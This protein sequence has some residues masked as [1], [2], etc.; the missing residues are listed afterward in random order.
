VLQERHKKVLTAGKHVCCIRLHNARRPGPAHASQSSTHAAAKP[1][2]RCYYKGCLHHGKRSSRNHPHHTTASAAHALHPRWLP[3]CMPHAHHTVGVAA[4]HDTCS[5]LLPAFVTPLHG[6]QVSHPPISYCTTLCQLHRAQLHPKRAAQC[7]PGT[8]GSPTQRLPTAMCVR[9]PVRHPLFCI[10]ARHQQLS[11]PNPSS[12]LLA[13]LLAA[14][15]A[16]ATPA[17][18]QQSTKQRCQPMPHKHIKQANLGSTTET[19]AMLSHGQPASV[20]AIVTQHRSAANLQTQAS[21]K[22]PW[23]RQRQAL[24][25]GETM[26]NISVTS[27]QILQHPSA[28]PSA[29]IRCGT[30]K[31]IVTSPAHTQQLNSGHCRT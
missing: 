12:Q 29:C 17:T 3:H 10:C 13:R 26:V 22:L 16:K 5:L 24:K 31:L 28:L 6:L 2:S 15:D 14:I 30:A 8:P 1:E 23:A 7:Q 27:I 25:L 20:K 4:T 11:T 21:I 18:L 9:T 19:Q